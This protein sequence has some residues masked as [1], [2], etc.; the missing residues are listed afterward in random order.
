[1][2]D[3]NRQVRGGIRW[4]WILLYVGLWTFLALLSAVQ[5]YVSMLVF[6]R[7]IPVALALERALEE[8]YLWALIGLGVIGLGQL[9][10]FES[11]RGTRWGLIHA[12]ASVVTSVLFVA[13]YALVL[14][15]Q[16]SIDGTLFTFTYVFKKVILHYFLV[17]VSMYWLF[18]LAQQGW[19][20]FNRYR[21]RERQ[22]I[23]LKSQLSQ[24]RLDALR[25]QLNP[26]FL[27]NTLHTIS[28][29]IHDHPDDADRMVARLSDLLRAS[30]EGPAT[31]EVP[32]RQELV[33]LDRYLEIEQIR[34]E[35]H[36]TIR[37]EVENEALDAVVPFL[38]LQPLVEN[39]IR[40]GVEAVNQKGRILIRAQRRQ[41][42][43]ELAVAD[44]GPGFPQIDDLPRREGVGLANTRSRLR[45]LY[46]DRHQV[47]FLEVPGG[48]L[49]VRLTLPLQ[50]PRAGKELTHVP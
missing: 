7:P 10:P 36:L 5:V 24:A 21:E 28:A 41:G 9:I 47:E 42:K 37:R 48:G 50:F 43:L 31:Q 15:G 2:V 19:H 29:L 3:V 8:W 22:A 20:Y 14:Q 11:G 33:F 6:E 12:G 17:N 13:L 26:H 30:L 23:E 35:D 40:H 18:L 44:N 39:A 46:G 16:R 49:E 25:M 27:F 45:H 4:R 32:L 1:M 38:I 34:F